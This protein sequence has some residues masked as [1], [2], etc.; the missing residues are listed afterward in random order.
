MEV[1]NAP[2]QLSTFGSSFHKLWEVSYT[3]VMQD[4]A[5]GEFSWCMFKFADC[6]NWNHATLVQFFS[7]IS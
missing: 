4:G 3:S 1:K 2:F 7:L 5:R 6:A